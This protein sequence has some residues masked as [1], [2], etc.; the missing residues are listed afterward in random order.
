[1]PDH[2]T[3]SSKISSLERVQFDHNAEGSKG[4]REDTLEVYESVWE[5][6]EECV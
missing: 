2:F 6:C 5:M 1:M 4:W 3:G